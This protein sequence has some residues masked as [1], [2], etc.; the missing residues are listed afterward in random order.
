MIELQTSRLTLRLPTLADWPAYRDF[1]ASDAAKHIGGPLPAVRSWY[2]FAGDRGHWDLHGFGWFTLD[3]GTGAVGTCGL[4]IPPHHAD[5]EIGWNV[6]GAGQGKGYAT[7]AARAVLDW[8]PSVTDAPRIVSY[9]D[10]ENTASKRVAEKLGAGFTG[11]M[12][13]HDPDCEVWLH[14]RRAA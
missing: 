14:Q 7:E 9:I 4:H 8:A 10:R 11:E 1:Y 5:I 6:Y 13:A 3:D 12:A 2:Y